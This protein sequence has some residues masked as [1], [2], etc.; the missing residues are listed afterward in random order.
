MCMKC[1]CCTPNDKI[2]AAPIVAPNGPSGK[3]VVVPAS[4][5]HP[6]GYDYR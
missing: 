2:V 1:G 4:D 5:T 3:Q 6:G